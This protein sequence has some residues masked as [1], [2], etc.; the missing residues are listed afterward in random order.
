MTISSRYLI[1]PEVP[2][3]YISMLTLKKKIDCRIS[4]LY[5]WSIAFL[6]LETSRIQTQTR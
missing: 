2:P 3:N 5:N 1:K 6:L 4:G